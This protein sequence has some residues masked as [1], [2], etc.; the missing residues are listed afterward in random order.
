MEKSYLKSSGTHTTEIVD[1]NTGEVIETITNKTTYL[2][3]TTE[4]FFL[5]YSSF[6]LVLKGSTDIRIKL[7]AYLIGKYSTGQP[8]QMGSGMKELIAEEFNCKPRS[9]DLAFTTLLKE[10][11]IIRLKPRLYRINPRHVFKGST[12]DRNKELKSVIELYCKN[13]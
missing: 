3:N 4:E 2:A 6:V 1:V 8:F 7:F 12:S 9:L 13:C 10:N 11:I 5:M